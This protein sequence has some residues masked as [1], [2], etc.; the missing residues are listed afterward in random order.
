[1]VPAEL[2][3]ATGRAVSTALAADCDVIV[4][5]NGTLGS[6][7]IFQYGQGMTTYGPNLG[8]FESS[9]QYE[10]YATLVHCLRVTEQ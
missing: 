9:F 6:V 10:S 5:R 7:L 3:R 8:D 4:S 2:R 1:M